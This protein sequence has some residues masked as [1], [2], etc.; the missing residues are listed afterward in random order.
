MCDCESEQVGRS[1]NPQFVTVGRL[2]VNPPDQY[3]AAG[4][5]DQ[6]QPPHMSW[7]ARTF[8]WQHG[9]RLSVLCSISELLPSLVW[10]V[11]TLTVHSIPYEK[12]KIKSGNER[13]EMTRRVGGDKCFVFWLTLFLRCRPNPPLPPS[14]CRPLC[15]TPQL[16]QCCCSFCST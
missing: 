9:T 8:K 12:Y 15:P 4:V 3:G 13:S 16:A 2:A 7:S 5:T 6:Y 10:C 14:W 1:L 11:H